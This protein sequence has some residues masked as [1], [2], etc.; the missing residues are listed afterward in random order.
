M[1]YLYNIFYQKSTLIM[2]IRVRFLV[3]MLFT[4]GKKIKYIVKPIHFLAVLKI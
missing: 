4:D 3:N 1:H 2:M